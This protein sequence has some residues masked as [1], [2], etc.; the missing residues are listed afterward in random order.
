MAGSQT[1]GSQTRIGE[2][3]TGWP[4]E[5]ERPR[6]GRFL[7]WPAKAIA[8]AAM[9][10]A[11]VLV[12]GFAGLVGL[13]PQLHNPFSERAVDR[14]QPA[15]LQS[16]QDL[17]RYEAAAG[18]FQV[19]I[20]LEKD[21][22]FLPAVIR[23][24]RTLF[25]AAGTVGVYVDFSTIGEDAVQ[26]SADRRSA[27]ITLPAPALDKTNLD[28]NRSYVFA[29]QRGILDRIGSLFSGNPGD[30]QDLY[31]LAEQKIQAAAKESG[32]VDRAEKNTRAMLVGLLNSLG[33]TSVTVNFAPPQP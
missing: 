32:L 27:T 15:I 8:I 25:V 24:E 18:N 14:S 9:V 1:G 23:G 7:S 33:F 10:T 22:R 4:P 6:R 2:T 28:S 3:G 26:V 11:A 31:V 16:I 5:E 19:V 12:A 13:L 30:Q 29:Q 21:A 17:S 20:D